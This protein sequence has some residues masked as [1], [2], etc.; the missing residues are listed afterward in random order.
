VSLRAVLQHLAVPVESTEAGGEWAEGERTRADEQPVPERAFN[1]ALF[2]PSP[3][4]E[5]TAR[6]SR[7]V[8]RP[9]LLVGPADG[10]QLSAEDKLDVTAPELTGAE[11]VRWQLEGDPQ[12][13]GRPGRRP[14][15]YVVNLRRVED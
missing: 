8:K 1:C 15:V 11:P 9:Q 2:L 14:R 7:R 3:N 12:P 10:G 4:E 13:A 6:G 5:T